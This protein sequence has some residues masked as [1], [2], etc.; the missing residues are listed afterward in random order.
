[1]AIGALL[2]TGKGL[3]GHTWAD[4]AVAWPPRTPPRRP[5]SSRRWGWW[6]R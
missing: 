1:M 2:L 6:E 3:D 5:W 4:A